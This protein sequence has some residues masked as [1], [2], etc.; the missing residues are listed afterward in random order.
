MECEII[1]LENDVI[2]S[3]P[4]YKG[5]CILVIAK[6]TNANK[7]KF[8][9]HCYKCHILANLGEH[10]V[11]IDEGKIVTLNPSVL[12]PRDSCKEHYWIKNGKIV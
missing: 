1:E 7:D 12:C 9:L 2:Y 5:R 4:E 11:K 3:K 8:W 10:V 6:V